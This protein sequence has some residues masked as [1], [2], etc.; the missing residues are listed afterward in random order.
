MGVGVG[1]AKEAGLRWELLDP[2]GPAL[3]CIYFS[4]SC[5]FNREAKGLISS[6][7]LWGLG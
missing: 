1:L 4:R 3:L 5:F 7:V 6:P 2:A